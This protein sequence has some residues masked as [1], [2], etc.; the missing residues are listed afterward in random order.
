MNVTKGGQWMP[1]KN[2]F[3][4]RFAGLPKANTYNEAG[5][6]AYSFSPKHSLAQYA[7]T[8]CFNNTLSL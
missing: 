3:A 5:G 1:N 6:V 8:G 4:T 7:C 2:L